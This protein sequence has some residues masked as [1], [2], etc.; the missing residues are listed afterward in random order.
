MAKLLT[1]KPTP[2]ELEPEATESPEAEQIDP[3]DYPDISADMEESIR[4]S[5]PYH[6]RWNRCLEF[7]RGNQS[8]TYDQASY[9]YG[10]A[11]PRRGKMTVEINKLLP[12]YRNITAR[13]ATAYPSMAVLPASDS[14]EDTLKS[15]GS[16][17]TLRYQWSAD[18]IKD[19]LGR[20]AALLVSTGNAGLHEY[21][22]AK[23]GDVC[24]DVIRP[25][26]LVFEPFVQSPDESDWVAIRSYTTKRDLLK[27]YP[28][29]AE[30]IEKYAPEPK[31]QRQTG[32]QSMPRNRVEYRQ[33]YWQD[34]RRALMLGSHYMWRGR[35]PQGIM[36]VQLVTYTKVE[37]FLWGIGLIEPLLGAQV[38]YNET[39]TQIIQNIRQMTNPKI[40]CYEGSLKDPAKAFT[41]DVGEKVW[42]TGS[43]PAP[44]A[45]QYPSLP[46]FAL[47]EP[48]RL[49][50]EIQD[51]SGIHSVSLGKR[52][53]GVSSGK[54]INAL[55]QNDMSQLQLTQE[56]IESAVVKMS[57]NVLVLMREHY[58]ERKMMRMLDRSGVVIFHELQATDL[59]DDPEIFLEAGTLFRTEAQDREARVLDLLERGLL[60]IDEA[61]EAMSFRVMPMDL[62]DRMESLRH[63]NDLLS[64]VI[65]IDAPV[66]V[67]P[68]D[69]HKTL[70]RVFGRFINSLEF[71]RLDPNVQDR[72]NAAYLV[73]LGAGKQSPAQSI[74]PAGDTKT[75][76]P[77]PM[78]EAVQGQREREAVESGAIADYGARQGAVEEMMATG[79]EL[80]AATP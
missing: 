36:P 38:L 63:A 24:T 25:F 74:A 67:Y 2:L 1:K 70:Q 43:A 42:L 75:M 13:L 80:A 45:F 68:T 17:Q 61:K 58:T 37:G 56:Y 32:P 6:W 69:D 53:A 22:D 47:E 59:V 3:A 52:V 31:N 12:L 55:S 44:A 46:G 30:A 57:T 62:A 73:I 14:P 15:K 28:E 72:I 8:S 48:A 21:F 5:E 40:L 41:Q 10:T 49:E 27:L 79:G 9:Q 60:T 29:S 11:R 16:E 4:L 66:Q 34:G 35:T 64:A 26:D 18:K 20:L 50:Q 23:K 77:D 76:S 65:R 33:V 51:Q 7:T 19:K 71:Y 78:D 54:A 39:R